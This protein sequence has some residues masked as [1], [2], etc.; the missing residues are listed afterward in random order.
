MIKH[1][2]GMVLVA[3]VGSAQVFAQVDSSKF[4]LKE[5]VVKENRMQIPFL[6]V[7]QNITLITKANIQATPARSV[8]EV[9][10][11]TPGIDV[12]QRGIS[13]VQADIGIRGGSF[14][15]TL[16][17]VNGIKLSDPQTGHHMMN[18]P[19]P[20]Q[21]IERI[22]V[23]KGQGSRIFGQNAYA[24]AINIITALPE[25][26]QSLFRVLV[27]ILEC[28]VVMCMLLYLSANTSR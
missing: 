13:G 7:S 20:L 6:K 9:L 22:D 10:A 27:V 8:Q 15:Q 21:A 14:E 16:I 4:V 3:F 19:V 1:I 12:R 11:F 24:G 2:S 28:W 18:I 25:K 17:L 26:N 5:V 23:L